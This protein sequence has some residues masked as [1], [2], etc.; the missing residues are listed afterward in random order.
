MA[1]GGDDNGDA[2]P[3]TATTSAQP[4]TQE[5][6]TSA[7]IFGEAIFIETRV[8]DARQ[9]VGVVVKT[10]VLGESPL[11]PGGKTTGGSEG[12]AITTTLHCPGGT[13]TMRYSPIQNSRVQGASW[14]VV[15]GTGTFAE[16]RG[17]G[18]MVAIFV[19]DDPDRGRELFTGTVGK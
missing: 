15:S 5:N 10:S 6:S 4:P 18:S 13:L 7:P 8:T 19:E 12:A 9:H 14:Q 11:C 17:G 2:R 3:T 16:L 1:C